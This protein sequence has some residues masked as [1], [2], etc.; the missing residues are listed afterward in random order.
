MILSE[1]NGAHYTCLKYNEVLIVDR[2]CY[3]LHK[4]QITNAQ[5]TR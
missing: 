4:A 3:K 5:K 2:V 1:T